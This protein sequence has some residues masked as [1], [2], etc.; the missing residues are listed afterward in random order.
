MLFCFLVQNFSEIRQSVD[1]LWPIKAI[2]KMAAAAILSFKISLFGYVTVIRFNIWCSVP[3]FIKL[4]RFFTDIWLYN[5][6]QNGGRPPS[7]ILKICSY[8]HMAFVGMPFCFCTQNFADIG[9]S[10]NEL[11]PKKRFSRWRSL[12]SWIPKISTL[13]SWL[14]SVQHLL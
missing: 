7:W 14:Q 5:D 4:G 9:Q 11:W 10:V 1:E 3:N 6:F 8:C 13:A 2:F 12:P